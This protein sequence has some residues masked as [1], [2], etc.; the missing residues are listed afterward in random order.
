MRTIA[1]YEP[2][3]TILLGLG[4][5]TPYFLVAGVFTFM[6]AFVP[7]TKVRLRAALIGG[8]AAGAA[9][10]FGGMIFTQFV[11]V[12]TQNAAIYA[13]FA[14]IIVA[15]MWLYISWLILLLGAQL[16]FYVQFP[17]YLRPGRGEI[18]LSSSLRERVA[19][20]IM[21]LIVSD[22]SSAQ[23][24]W[25][26]ARIAE[27]LDL[28]AA[29][30]SP[31]MD[32]LERR[33]LLLVA[34]DDTWVPARDPHSMDLADVLDAVRHD[35]GGPR[36]GRCRDVGPAVEA[37]RAAEE[38]LQSSLKGRTVAQLVELEKRQ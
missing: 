9:W 34:E 10:A 6:Y 15:L 25:T 14:I 11:G 4:S 30:L 22:Y 35:T 13:G 36:L 23:H 21:Y 24:R 8:I 29:A 37:A 2:F 16:S 33:R 19:L 5:L 17:Q 1:Q 3:G 18:H 28:P 7:N 27:H 12:S 26:I 38:A 32:A 31:I 20:S